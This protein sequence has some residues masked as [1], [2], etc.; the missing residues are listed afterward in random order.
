MYA[1]A[2]PGEHDVQARRFGGSVERV[3]GG[4]RCWRREGR[5][6]R[7]GAECES[8]DAPP[9]TE[10][11]GHGPVRA[12]ERWD[13]EPEAR[14]TQLGAELTETNTCDQATRGSLD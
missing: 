6:W 3:Q 13:G 7:E 14:V 1:R 9:R 4:A 2:H 10:S 11:S 12:S 8:A 5:I